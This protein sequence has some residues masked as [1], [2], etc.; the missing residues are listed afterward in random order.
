MPEVR[1]SFHMTGA[2]SGFE[3]STPES[4]TATM[5]SESEAASA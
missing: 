4:M 3:A 1:P 5:T 2:R